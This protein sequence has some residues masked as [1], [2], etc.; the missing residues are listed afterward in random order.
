VLGY[1]PHVTAEPSH[2]PGW[3]WPAWARVVTAGG[4]GYGLARW[5]VPVDGP[6]WRAVA[7]AVTLAL[8]TPTTL[9]A[10]RWSPRGLWS[11]LALVSA[12]GLYLGVPETDHLV[13]VAGGLAVLV[14]ADLAGRVRMDGLVVLALAAAVVWVGVWGAVSRAGALT[15]AMALLGLLL[16]APVAERLPG[17]ARPWVPARAQVVALLLLQALFV[18]GGA[19]FGALRSDA[20]DGAVVGILGL[21]L[22][23]WLARLVIG[24]RPW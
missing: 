16:V 13:A 3:S 7:A 1:G 21:A 5:A 10:D 24:P 19:R 23:A 20:I 8:V 12:G 6:P 18:V 11:G 4:V 9:L 22:L 15:A 2:H 17:P 14:V